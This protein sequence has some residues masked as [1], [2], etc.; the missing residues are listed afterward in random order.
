MRAIVLLSVLSL[1]SVAQVDRQL[2][3]KYF[4]EADALC[5]R[6]GGKLWGVPLCGP[7]AFADAAT[8]SIATNRPEP[9]GPRPPALGFAN[10]AIDWGGEKWSIFVWRMVP[11]DDTD[12]RARLMMHELFHRI[13]DRIGFTASEGRNDH[14]DTLD[15]RYWMQLEWRALAKALGASGEERAS[16]IRDALAFRAARRRQF[17]AAAEN[18]RRLENNEGL[19]QYTGTV[20][21]TS[22]TAAAL[23]SGIAQLDRAA[24]NGGFVRT[25][26]YPSG[27]AY[28]LL[29]DAYSPG[30]TRRTKLEDDLGGL[31]MAAAR[32]EPAPDAAAVAERYGAADLRSAERKRETAYED[33]IAALTKKFVDGPVL[34]IPPGRGYTFRTDGI[35]PIPG[36]GT[37]YPSFR[38]DGAWGSFEAAEVMIAPDRRLHVPAPSK[39]AGSTIQGEGWTLRL[40]A[41]WA[42]KAGARTGDFEVV[43]IPAP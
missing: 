33:R 23:A 3:T 10:S 34:V 14:L 15:G 41:G 42:V 2:A 26:P 43:P 17:P 16:A 20:A 11:Q 35:T 37:V 40:E 30:W 6:E 22:G 31:L 19:A 29:L 4:E 1:P 18:E 36:K 32:L 24:K 8:K 7:M 27:A 39:T 25:F 21:S 12:S 13:Q 5:R 28:G 38:T 9:S